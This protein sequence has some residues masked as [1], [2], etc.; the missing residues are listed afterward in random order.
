MKHKSFDQQT[1]MSNFQ[2]I[3]DLA[4]EAITSFLTTLPTLNSAIE[5]ALRAKNAS[6]LELNAHTLK[7]AVS[8][9]YAEQSRSLAFELEVMGKEKKLERAEETFL[10]LKEELKLLSIELNK[11]IEQKAVA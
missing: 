1:F 6:D 7:G 2:G 9:F 4:Y 8:N 11:F 3:E 5:A 10:L